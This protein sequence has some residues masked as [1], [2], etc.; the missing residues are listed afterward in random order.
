MPYTFGSAGGAAITDSSGK[1]VSCVVGDGRQATWVWN[2]LNLCQLCYQNLNA[3]NL[4]SSPASLAT[5]LAALTAN[6]NKNL[7]GT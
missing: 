5:I 7:R 3:L 2:S 1:A 4:Q 6:K